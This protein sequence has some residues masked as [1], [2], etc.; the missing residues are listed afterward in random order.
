[1][2]CKKCGTEISDIAKFCPKCGFNVKTEQKQQNEIKEDNEIRYTIKPEFNLLYKFITNL[3]RSLLYLLII[4]FIFTNLYKL[5]FI[6][7]GTALI[8]IGIMLGYIII[9]MFF[10]KMQ[11]NK[12]E[13]NFY[14]T[15][16]EYKDGFLNKEEKELKYKSIREITMN[17]NILERLCGIGTIRIFT[18]ASSGFGNPREKGRSINGIYIHCVKNVQEQ[19][20]LVKQ[21]IYEGT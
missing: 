3:G 1:M 4:C 12:L 16:I 13:Y 7:P 9:K 19:Y 15:K 2:F 20:K 8:T 21:I 11:Y 10:E 14:L 17:Q 5:W 18:N 6:Y